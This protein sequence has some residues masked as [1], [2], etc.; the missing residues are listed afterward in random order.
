MS[1]AQDLSRELNSSGLPPQSQPHLALKLNFLPLGEKRRVQLATP[2]TFADLHALATKLAPSTGSYVFKYVDPE[3]QT[4]TTLRIDDDIAE[5]L[6][7]CNKEGATLLLDVVS[8]SSA[9]PVPVGAVPESAPSNV[10]HDG[11]TCDDC[12]A[13]PICGVRFKCLVRHDFDLCSACEGKSPQPFAMCKVSTPEQMPAAL[14]VGLRDD[15]PAQRGRGGG[16]GGGWR[17]HGPPHVPFGLGHHGPPSHHA[18]P[19]PHPHPHPHHGAWAAGGGAA[20]PPFHHPHGPP[21]PPP[22]LAAQHLMARFVRDESFPDGSPVEKDTVFEKAWVVRNDGQ[23]SWPAGTMLKFV[24]GD[25]MAVELP[26]VPTVAPGELV[27]LRVQLKTPPMCGRFVSY[28]RLTGPRGAPFGQRLWAD[29]RSV[30]SEADEEEHEAAAVAA[31]VAAAAQADEDDIAR[32]EA[33][34]AAGMTTPAPTAAPP[35]AAAPSPSPSPELAMMQSLLGGGAQADR[36]APLLSAIAS[37]SQQQGGLGSGEDIGRLVAG[38]LHAAGRPS[39][40]T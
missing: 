17:R 28:F 30:E 19:G 3:D 5:W 25:E 33:E 18:P 6:R 24:S 14:V 13:S 34:H 32:V 40:S 29:V 8:E 21:P 12:G 7:L 10:V 26:A 1:S 20:P 15:P 22:P 37:S 16:G 27:T 9:A 4:P 36:F 2:V 11:V 23:V 31:A 39:P 35:A 38:I